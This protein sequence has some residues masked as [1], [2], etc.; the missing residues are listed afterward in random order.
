MAG[1]AWLLREVVRHGSPMD[2][3]PA[4]HEREGSVRTGEDLQ[5][6]GGEVVV[7]WGAV[8]EVEG[9]GVGNGD[10]GGDGGEGVAG[11]GTA[12]DGFGA[13]GFVAEECA[14]DIGID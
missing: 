6:V 8:A 10:E 2:F 12:A 1:G 11:T 9:A 13:A 4:H 5:A 7:G 14:A 3:E